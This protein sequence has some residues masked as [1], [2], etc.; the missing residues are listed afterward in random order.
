MP[1]ESMT[2]ATISAWAESVTVV[3]KHSSSEYRCFIQ[4]LGYWLL[5]TKELGTR[6]LGTRD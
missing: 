5:E 3:S 2:V 4:I 6:E 1:L